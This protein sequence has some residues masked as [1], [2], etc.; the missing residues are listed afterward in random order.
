MKRAFAAFILALASLTGLAF[1]QDQIPIQL[2]LTSAMTGKVDYYL[3]PASGS[4]SYVGSIQP[5]ATIQIESRQGQVY[6]FAENR[7][8]F[9]KYTVR[10]EKFQHLTVGSKEQQRLQVANE[11]QGTPD[12]MQPPEATDDPL[13][14]QGQQNAAPADA[15]GMVWQASQIASEVE[16]GAV[17]VQLVLG[18]PET[19]AVQFVATC[20]PSAGGIPLVQISGDVPQ[21][22]DG[23]A[24][25]VR[26]ATTGFDQTLDGQIMRPASEEGMQGASLKIPS[27]D[28]FWKALPQLS[29]LVY[30]IGRA[31]VA[32][33]SLSGIARPLA[34]FLHDCAT[35]GRGDSPVAA[36]PSM[37]ATSLFQDDGAGGQQSATTS[38]GGNPA[39]DQSCERLRTARAKPG[40]QTLSVTF[41]N[42]TNE[43][44]VLMMIDDEGMPVE[45]AQLEGGQS[46]K[47]ETTTTEPWMMT[48]G[49]GNC[50][51]MMVPSANRATFAMTRV[52]P[53]FGPDGD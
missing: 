42:K 44:R 7:A 6:L 22:P 50:I 25:K 17:N 28:P 14:Q 36:A 45:F 1:A 21:F 52:S 37:P 33:L 9:Q 27:S 46:F 10:A 15:S 13:E 34:A 40:G 31:Q 24:V 49:P 38:S 4:P 16:E 48:D 2:R 20:D 30:S 47:I 41:V 35:L 18:I 29:S 51:E 8:P 32:P 12:T 5:G 3:S 26:F 23:T 43:Y 53:G 11:Y 39:V 19:D